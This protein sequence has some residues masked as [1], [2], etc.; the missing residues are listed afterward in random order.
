MSFALATTFPLWA[1]TIGAV[2]FVL[3]LPQLLYT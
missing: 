1:F 3:L 2:M